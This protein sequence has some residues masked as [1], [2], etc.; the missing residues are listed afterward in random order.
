MK[1]IRVTPMDQVC[2]HELFSE[3]VLKTSWGGQLLGNQFDLIFPTLGN[4]KEADP[5]PFFVGMKDTVAKKQFRF[6]LLD[7]SDPQRFVIRATPLGAEPKSLFNDILITL[8]RERCLPVAVVYRRGWRGKDT[9]Q[10]T[11]IEANLDR[12]FADAAFE[13]EKLEG[14]AI[15]YESPSK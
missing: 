5:L 7:A 12:P 10:F 15:T 11:L 8:D 4:P 1:E 9:K 2:K 14:W 3:E 13:P 6:E